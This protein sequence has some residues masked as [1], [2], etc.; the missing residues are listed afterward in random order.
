MI[1]SRGYRIELG[2]IETILS[3]HSKIKENAVIALPSEEFG[4]AISAVLVAELNTDLYEEEVRRFC[5]EN[6]PVYMV[7]E[8]IHF[9]SALPRTSTGKID[10]TAV[11]ELIP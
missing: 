7:P 8:T 1:K 3:A 2:E 6:L 9:V 4:S 10:R 5:S 11:A